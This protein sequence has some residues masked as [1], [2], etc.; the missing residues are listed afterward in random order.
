VVAANRIGNEGGQV[1]Y[2]TSF[3]TDQTGEIVTDFGR[4]EEG[5]LIATFDLDQIDRER[6]AWGFFRDRRTDLYDPL[7]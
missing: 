3:I 7:L 6:A 5:V 4:K 2:G 1:F